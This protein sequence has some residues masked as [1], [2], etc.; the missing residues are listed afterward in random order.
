[1]SCLHETHRVMQFLMGLNE[2]FDHSKDQILLMDPLPSV[3]KAYS[4]ILKVEK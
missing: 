2:V 4:M 3:N 1:M